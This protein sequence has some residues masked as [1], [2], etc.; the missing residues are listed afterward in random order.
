[1]L[2]GHAIPA[3]RSAIQAE[4]LG[5]VA[6]G[7]PVEAARS[8]ME[9]L[10][11]KCLYGR[12]SDKNPCGYLPPRTLPE[13][14]GTDNGYASRA[15]RFHSLVCT[16]RVN[17]VGN[18]S[19]LYFP[20]TVTLPYDEDGRITDVEVA[21]LLPT[22]SPYAGFF[23]RR[24]E[25][26]EPIGLSV[27]E[28]RAVMQGHQFLCAHA[29]P[30]KQTGD[31]RPYLDCYAYDERPLGGDIVRVH[32]FYDEAGTVTEVEVIQWEGEFDGLCCM[33]P[34]RSDTLAGGVVKAALLPARLSAILLL[35][36]VAAAV[37]P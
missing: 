30:A 4:I 8:G 27:E 34:N 28:A 17:R 10:G 2:L 22:Q 20:I 1:M 9:E 15:K 32:L 29:R 14:L 5:H 18:W 37:H 24:P 21:N 23:Q 7:L 26:R 11:F 31:R 13:L 3:D 16:T 33:L 35:A 36:Y 12:F 19:Q 6:L 25:L